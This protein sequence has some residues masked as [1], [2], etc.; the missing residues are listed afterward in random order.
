MD[1]KKLKENPKNPRTLSKEQGKHLEESL[2]KFGQCEPVVINQDG[3]I[4]GGHQRVRTLKKLGYKTVDVYVPDTILDEKEVEELSIRLNK[5]TGE[6]DWEILGN[7]WEVEDLLKWGFTQD[8]LDVDIEVIDGTGPD[9]EE[10]EPPKEAKSK[11]GDFYVLGNHRLL[12]GDSTNPDDVKKLLEG[13]EPILMVTDPPYGVDYKPEWRNGKDGKAGKGIRTSGK[14]QNDDKVNWA[15][16][17]HL[18]PGAVAYV[19]HAAWFG[20]EVQKS[21]ENADFE[22]KSQIIWAKQNFALS[23]GDYHWKH[24]PC[25]YAVKKGSSHNW[26]GSRKECTIWEI[27]NLSAFGISH[28]E[29]ERTNHSTQ[30]PLECMSTPI[31]NNSAEGESVYDPF[32]GSGTTLISCEQLK[33][34]AYCMELDPIYCDMIVNRWVNFM[35]KKNEEYK[36][37]LNDKKID[38]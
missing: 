31:R 30:K 35:K 5:N 33:R 20:G 19:W 17:W 28:E 22:I 11:L 36:V 26:Q 32:T 38:W 6:W 27:N 16:A 3:L 29:D 8:E 15:L 34:N 1:L 18:F 14:V 25:F 4:I 7:E 37:I 9:D 24:E 21:L 13:A 10:I 23:R 12:C 2:S